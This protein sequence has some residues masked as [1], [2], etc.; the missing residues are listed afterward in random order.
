MPHPSAVHVSSPPYRDQ[1]CDIMPDR[2]AA[3]KQSVM[4]EKMGADAKGYVNGIYRDIA[5]R[6]GSGRYQGGLIAGA[7]CIKEVNTL[8][9]RC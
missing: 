4:E 3:E 6:D 1:R 9:D 7:V 2:L 5:L 8:W